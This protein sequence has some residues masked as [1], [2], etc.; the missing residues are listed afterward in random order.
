MLP[1]IFV[2]AARTGFS[3]KRLE[4]RQA[5]SYDRLDACDNNWPVALIGLMYNCFTELVLCVAVD[6]VG[7]RD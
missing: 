5:L 1:K 3:C 2:R 7:E 4:A 6:E